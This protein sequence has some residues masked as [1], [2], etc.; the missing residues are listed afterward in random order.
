VSDNVVV[1]PSYKRFRGGVAY[2]PLSIGDH[3][4]IGEDSVV[5]AATIGSYVHIGKNCVIS[6]RCIL[7]D[8]CRIPDNSILA[9]DTVV[10]PFTTYNRSGMP[11]EELPECFQDVM[12]DYTT[13]YYEQFTN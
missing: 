8:C 3:V 7:K 4:M 13:L 2:F 1:R 11:M 10:P 5:A 6:K 12:K 9:P